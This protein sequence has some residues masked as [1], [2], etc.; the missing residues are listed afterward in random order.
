[1]ASITLNFSAANASRIQKALERRVNPVDGNG[2]PRPA[3]LADF[4]EWLVEATR[5]TVVASEAA[6]AREALAA[7]VDVDIT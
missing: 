5:K 2:D 3:T 7:P 6:D 4:K 1:M